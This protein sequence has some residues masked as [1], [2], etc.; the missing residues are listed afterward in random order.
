MPE[1]PSFYDALG[2]ADALHRL[3]DSFYGQVL[4]DP[5]LAPVFAHFTP[6]HVEH[7]VV[8]LTEVFGGPAEYTKRL[9]GHH[10]LLSHHAGLAITEEQRARW[11]ELLLATAAKEL[12]E[13]ALLQQ[14]FAEYVEWGTRIAKSVSQ[15]GA[16][17]GDPGPTPR[18]GWNGPA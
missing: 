7:V 15:P 16:E 1:Q 2:G 18:W 12:P 5:L 10:G 11:A 6:T 13:D 9:G 8:W 17:L 14:R 3:I 4:Q